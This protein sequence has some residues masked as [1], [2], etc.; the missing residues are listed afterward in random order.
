[1]TVILTFLRAESH[2]QQALCPLNQ[3]LN[4]AGNKQVFIFQVWGL[5]APVTESQNFRIAEDFWVY[6]AL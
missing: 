5:L 3:Q 6:L 1:M 4:K 2:L